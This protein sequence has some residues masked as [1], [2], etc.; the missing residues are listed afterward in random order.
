[1]KKILLRVTGVGAEV[2]AGEIQQTLGR[3][4]AFGKV[5]LAQRL[6]HPNIDGERL[7]KTVGEEQGAV[8]DLVTDT[9][10]AHQRFASR[11]HIE[12]TER[13]QIQFTRSNATRGGEQAG[14]AKAHLAGAQFRFSRGCQAF[15]R[16]ERT[17]EERAGRGEEWFT[18]PFAEQGD[19]LLN[20]ND[21]LGRGENE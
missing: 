15:N 1:M 19:D 12:V 20:L 11:I 13:F 9:A 21:L 18:K 2:R 10:Q 6:H 8:G 4:P 17:S 3:G 7:L 14:R 16:R 5:K